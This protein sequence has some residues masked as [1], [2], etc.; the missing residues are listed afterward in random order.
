MLNSAS[1]LWPGYTE[2][3]THHHV[4]L[5]ALMSTVKS[6]EKLP[7]WGERQTFRTMEQLC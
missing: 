6:R 4:L 7:V 3:S 1:Y 2:D 5:I